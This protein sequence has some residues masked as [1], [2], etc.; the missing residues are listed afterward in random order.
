MTLDC[1]RKKQS[2]VF[3]VEI[4]ENSNEQDFKKAEKW[5]RKYWLLLVFSH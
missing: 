4:K 1:L 3:F 2:K 5:P